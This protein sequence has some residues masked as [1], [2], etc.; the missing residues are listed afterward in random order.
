MIATILASILLTAAPE[1]KGHRHTVQG[2]LFVSCHVVKH[3]KVDVH[4]SPDGGVENAPEC[5]RVETAKTDAG[6]VVTVNF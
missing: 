5:A 1:S 6:T 4:V 2:T 3:A